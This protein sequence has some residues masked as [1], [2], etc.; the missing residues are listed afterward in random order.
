MNEKLDK[1]TE[2]TQN[3]ENKLN[4]IQKKMIEHENKLNQLEEEKEQLRTEMVQKTNLIL[5]QLDRQ[6]QYIR[7]NTFICGIEQ[8]WR[9]YGTRATGCTHRPLCGHAH[10][11]SSTEFVSRKIEGRGVRL[12]PKSGQPPEMTLLRRGGLITPTPVLNQEHPLTQHVTSEI[13][14]FGNITA[15]YSTI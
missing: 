15:S 9:T 8:W 13:I 7:E 12:L 6:E 4:G 11:R 5:F 14:P 3:L 10:R 1:L 2:L